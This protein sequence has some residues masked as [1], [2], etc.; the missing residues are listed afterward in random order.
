MV[1]NPCPECTQPISSHAL[2][3][4]RDVALLEDRIEHDQQVEIDGLERERLIH[5]LNTAHAA[6]LYGHR[7]SRCLH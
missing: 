2:R 6:R 7:P 1:V 4:P 3:C 5:R